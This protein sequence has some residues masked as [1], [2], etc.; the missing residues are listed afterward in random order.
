M[1]HKYEGKSKNT[2]IKKEKGLIVGFEKSYEN[3]FKDLE[4]LNPKDKKTMAE[5]EEYQ[6]KTGKY[7][8]AKKPVYNSEKMWDILEAEIPALKKYRKSVREDK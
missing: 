6:N 4:K 5:F 7:E 1:K 2:F 3:K 8:V